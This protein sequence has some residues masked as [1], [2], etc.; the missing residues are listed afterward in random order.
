MDKLKEL[1]KS[2][3]GVSLITL[4]FLLVLSGTFIGIGM[5]MQTPERE[6]A[7]RYK[8]NR[9]NELIEQNELSVIID[10]LSDENDF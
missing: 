4:I 5:N 3:K 1:V 10:S 7:R 9:E 2:A 8:E 6:A